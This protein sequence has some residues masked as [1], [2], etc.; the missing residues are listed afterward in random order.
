MFTFENVYIHA[1]HINDFYEWHV[2]LETFSYILL[3]FKARLF[4]SEVYYCN[5]GGNPLKEIVLCE[6]KVYNSL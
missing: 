3:I 1:L 6:F 4:D 5:L 2:F